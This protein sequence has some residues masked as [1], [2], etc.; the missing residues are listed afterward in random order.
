MA[1][2]TKKQREAMADRLS[3]GIGHVPSMDDLVEFYEVAMREAYL[4]LK[5]KDLRE[6]YDEAFGEDEDQD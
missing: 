1:K 3:D 6:V 4:S 2:L 5:D